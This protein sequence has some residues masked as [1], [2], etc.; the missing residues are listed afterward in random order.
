MKPPF[1][2]TNNILNLAAEITLSLGQYEGLRMPVPQPELRKHTKIITIQSSL[3]IEG[4]TL[5][6]G[7]VTD[8]INNKRVMGPKK[9]IIEVKNAI[10]VYDMISQFIPNELSSLLKAH[11]ILMD[12]LITDAGQLRKGNVGVKAGE[13]IVHMAPSHKIVPKLMDNLFSFLQ[14]EKELHPLIKSSIFHY[15]FEFIHPFMDGNGRIGRL[16]QSVILYHYKKIFEYIPVETVVRRRQMEYYDALQQSAKSAESTVFIQFMLETIK[17]ATIEFTKNVKPVKQSTSFRID[18]AKKY[19]GKA[20]F[21][22]KQYLQLHNNIST[23][24]GSRDLTIAVQKGILIKTG[25]KATTRY[26]FVKLKN[27][28]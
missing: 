11:K 26:K 6:I 9:D 27:I 13:E 20:D 4:N 2:I 21:S 28:S 12:G 3:A 22:R 5:T 8:I 1:V 7:Q 15:E 17:E 14:E 25:E 19:F 10:K 18:I 16:W 23:A 24:T